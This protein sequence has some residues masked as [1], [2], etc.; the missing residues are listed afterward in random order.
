MA[1]RMAS[2]STP[3]ASTPW[4]RRSSRATPSFSTTCCSTRRLALGTPSNACAAPLPPARQPRLRTFEQGLATFETELRGAAIRFIPDLGREIEKASDGFKPPKHRGVG[5]VALARAEAPYAVPRRV[6]S[7]GSAISRANLPTAGTAMSSQ[8]S[9]TG[10]G[11]AR[12]KMYADARVC[13]E[14]L[15]R[16]GSGIAVTSLSGLTR[17]AHDELRQARCDRVP[18]HANWDTI[19][20]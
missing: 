3:T 17:L 4:F 1:S 7:T 13:V 15:R 18:R 6:P 2:V 11:E 16:P 20:Q 8:P 10:R 5:P 12:D 9:G 14:F 19:V